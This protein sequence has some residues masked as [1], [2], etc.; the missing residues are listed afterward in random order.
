[1]FVPETRV[2]CLLAASPLYCEFVALS[3]V[4]VP[5]VFA[6]TTSCASV[7]KFSSAHRERETIGAVGSVE[8]TEIFVP[9]TTLS[10]CPPPLPPVELIVKFG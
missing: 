1:M 9:P 5:L 10:T 8:S 4:F 2:S 6:I 7:T 3:P